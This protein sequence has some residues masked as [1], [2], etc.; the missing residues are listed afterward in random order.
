MDEVRSGAR[1]ILITGTS[2]GIGL[3][4][5]VELASR[6]ERVFASMRDLTRAEALLHAAGE[7]GVSVELVNLD[8]T[9]EESVRAAIAHVVSV[10]GRLDVVVNNAAVMSLAPVEFTPSAAIWSMFDTNIIGAIRVVQAA[11]PIMRRQGFGRIV[12]VGSVSAEPRTGLR[13][14][15]VYAA[16]KA[17]LHALSLELNKE[18]APLGIE[19]VL[20]EG[21]IGGRTAMF[22]ALH[23]GVA[24]FDSRDDAYARVEAT[25]RSFTAVLDANMP[26]PGPAAVIIAD[27]CTVSD[28]GV[29][30]PLAAQASIDSAHAI[31]DDDYL[32]L[33]CYDDVQSI[34]KQYGTA[35]SWLIGS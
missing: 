9:S 8:V 24:A 27:A 28:P 23:D 22:G 4:A 14:M 30:H 1:V 7:A 17:A 29:R 34:V 26:E 5:A 20:C 16:T 11:L 18:L 19:V 2:T 32:R 21:G 6:G 15:G 13:L 33:C 31:D 10:A 3:H 25:A 35:P 12:N